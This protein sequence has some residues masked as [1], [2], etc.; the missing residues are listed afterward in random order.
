MKTSIKVKNGVNTVSFDNTLYVPDLRTNL[1]S[2]SKITDKGYQV[3]FNKN[4]AEVISEADGSV[5]LVARRVDALYY[6]QAES[7]A[8]CNNITYDSDTKKPTSITL[9]EL[10]IRMGHVN[11]QYLRDAV[12]KETIWGVTVKDVDE[13]FKC[14][15]CV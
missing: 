14:E 3:T 10:C 4:G 8:R 12:K 15:V 11:L 1:I 6:C 2:V 9:K 13:N 7:N 5:A